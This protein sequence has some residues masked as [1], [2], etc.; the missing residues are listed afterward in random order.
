MFIS[1]R[2]GA[3]GL[4]LLVPH[5]G[6]AQARRLFPADTVLFVCEHGTVKSLVAKLEF[7]RQA[8]AAGLTTVALSRGSA[9][10]TAVPPWMRT[11]LA[12]DGIDLGD[13][14][15]QPLRAADL[16]SAALVISF[17]LPPGVTAEARAPRAQWD[18]LPSVSQDYAGGRDAIH[19]RVR[20]LV[21]SLK[22]ARR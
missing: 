2:A 14:T 15:P 8:R 17:D 22:R 19:R 9:A 11:A 4:A 3:V 16:K 20:L 12:G 5:K 21:D 7:E 1:W 6:V 10:D 18:G 13:W